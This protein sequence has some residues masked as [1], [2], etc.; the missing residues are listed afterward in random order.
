MNRGINVCLEVDHKIPKE[1]QMTNVSLRYKCDTEKNSNLFC[2]QT[3]GQ[4]SSFQ[5]QAVSGGN[6]ITITNSNRLRA[7]RWFKPSFLIQI[8]A[9]YP[10]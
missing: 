6:T 1:V 4:N 7:S 9:N 8:D 10:H 3:T 2:V 5:S